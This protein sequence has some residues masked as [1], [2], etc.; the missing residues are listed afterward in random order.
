MLLFSGCFLF[1][2]FSAFHLTVLNKKF[3]TV[4]KLLLSRAKDESAAKNEC[5]KFARYE[6][7]ARDILRCFY[8]LMRR[9]KSFQKLNR[10]KRFGEMSGYEKLKHPSVLYLSSVGVKFKKNRATF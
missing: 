2:Q 8:F 1:I 10:L 3:Y 6:Q 7:L 4:G 9:N 5:L